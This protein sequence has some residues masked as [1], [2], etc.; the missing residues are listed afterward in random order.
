MFC[1]RSN[2]NSVVVYIPPGHRRDITINLLGR[3]MNKSVETDARSSK[4]KTLHNTNVR[5]SLHNVLQMLQYLPT[6]NFKT[7]CL[8]ENTDKTIIA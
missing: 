8:Q 4:Q 2:R 1:D 5:I 3:C 7:M 6:K